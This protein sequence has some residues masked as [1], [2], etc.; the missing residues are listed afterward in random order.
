VNAVQSTDTSLAFALVR[1]M[2]RDCYLAGG[3]ESDNGVSL[4]TY[5]S[6]L[7]TLLRLGASV[8]GS[9]ESL[10]SETAK[11]L[12]NLERM[13]HHWEQD[14]MDLSQLSFFSFLGRGYSLGC[15]REAALLFQEPAR[16]PANWYN[17]AE[18]RQG[19]IEVLEPDHGVIVFAPDGPTREL[20]RAFVEELKLT[21][22]RVIEIAPPWPDIPEYL[23]SITQ[24]IPVQF[25]AYRLAAANHRP[26][27]FRFAADTTVSETRV[28]REQ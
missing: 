9:L 15:A 5:T 18:F 20:N 2:G 16:R 25:M 8:S 14:D 21:R 27:S 23:A 3:G 19:P 10:Q 13:I 12:P 17:G 22:A 1:T 11:L 6:T 28:A 24:M 26:G 4:R 7:L